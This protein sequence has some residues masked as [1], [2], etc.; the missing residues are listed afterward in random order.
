[1][2]CVM[3]RTLADIEIKTNQWSKA[4]SDLTELLAAYSFIFPDDPF[5]MGHELGRRFVCLLTFKLF[6]VPPKNTKS[7]VLLFR[8]YQL[9]KAMKETG[10]QKAGE[11]AKLVTTILN[12]CV[13]NEHRVLQRVKNEL[14]ET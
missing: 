7:N 12:I 4:V 3:R 1:M 11:T 13:G 5:I 6:Y 2:K 8:Y 10:H 9:A 14:L